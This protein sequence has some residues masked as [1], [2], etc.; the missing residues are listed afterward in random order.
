MQ[1]DK[2]FQR[3]TLITSDAAMAA[4]AHGG[5]AKCLQ[6]LIRLD[7]PVPTTVALCFSTVHDAASGQL[8]DLSQILA[9][10]GAAPLLSVRPSSQEPDW[11]GPGAILNIGMNDD[12][13][14]KMGKSIGEEAATSLYLRFIQSY[15]VHV[16]R[17][18]PDAFYIPDTLNAQA[19]RDML[20]SFEEE[21]DEPFPQSIEVQLAAVLRSMARA[22]EGTT[23]R[24]LRQAKG[25]PADAGLG[26]VVQAMALGVGAGVSGS[27]VIQFVDAATGAPQITG[28]YLSQ[29]QG[30]EALTAGG[31]T[32]YLTK[33][34][35]GTSLEELCPN[36]FADL[37]KFGAAVRARL[38]EEM[39][40][41]FTLEDGKILIL[42]GVRVERSA[43]AA[44]RIAVT[45]AQ[46]GIIGEDEAVMR[47]APSALSEL[48]HKQV[49]PEAK[50]DVIGR[51]IAAS[52]GAASG[53]IVF[54][55]EAAQASAARGEACILVR[56]ETTPEDI[57][58]MH[59][60]E[61]V[62][63]LRGGVT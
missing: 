63:T 51:G 30:R 22:W 53:K 31:D 54:T 12:A 7:L 48:L 46:D 43:R 45:L 21:M 2:R 40:I 44:L 41:E 8:P 1:Q 38:R 3:V 17:L 35:R 26:L 57:R 16:V 62:V 9:H 27:G 15:A 13:Y 33:G 11:G 14:A 32:I 39:Q 36:C 61:G 50:R 49:D 5:R 29:S 23:A 55:A 24:L 59:A 6:R 52:P 60:A 25:A 18:D 28:R 20:R 58:G 56:R 37:V 42:D 4:N 19:V 47:I 10:F 34:A